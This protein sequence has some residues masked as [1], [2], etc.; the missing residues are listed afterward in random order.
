[1]TKEERS[2]IIKELIRAFLT[3]VAIAGAVLF[4]AGVVENPYITVTINWIRCV[5]GAVLFLIAERLYKWI[6]NSTV[7]RGERD[8]SKR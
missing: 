8:D 3:L 1:M 7:K 2:R 6:F 5:V 4:V